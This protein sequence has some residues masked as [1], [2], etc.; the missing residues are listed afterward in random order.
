MH[1]G[2]LSQII[3]DL[4]TR[5]S[6]ADINDD[7]WKTVP[8]AKDPLSKKLTSY[9]IDILGDLSVLLAAIS[10]RPESQ[11]NGTSEGVLKSL[12]TVVEHLHD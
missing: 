5:K 7:S 4:I 11:H 6:A 1:A 3:R 8:W 9:L 10:Q 12:Y 2:Y